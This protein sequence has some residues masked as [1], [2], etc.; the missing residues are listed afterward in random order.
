MGAVEVRAEQIPAGTESRTGRL[1]A[2]IGLDGAGKS[3]QV[4]ML[5]EWLRSQG[6]PGQAHQSVTMAPVRKSLNAI[7]QQEGL[8]DHLELIGGETMRLISACSQLARV[9]A[10]EPT[11]TTSPDVVIVDRFVYCQYALAKAEG[12][13][14]IDF[15]RRLLGAAPKPDLTIFLDVSPAEAVRRINVRGIDEESP[16]FL[17][18]FRDAYIDLP[19]FSEFVSIPGDGDFETV[20]LAMRQAIADA[21]PEFFPKAS[22]T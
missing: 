21:F 22:A 9:A 6:V 7:A 12:V 10:L 4:R 2:V 15:L 5:G 11:V 3:T 1:V 20:Q 13:G 8:A 17:E 14:S 19:E 16:E 18:A